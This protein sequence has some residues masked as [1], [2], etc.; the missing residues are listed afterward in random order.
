MNHSDTLRVGVFSGVR[1]V[2]LTSCCV[3]VLPPRRYFLFP[4]TFPMIALVRPMGS[5]PGWS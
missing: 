1:N 4:K 3:I 2:F 5:M